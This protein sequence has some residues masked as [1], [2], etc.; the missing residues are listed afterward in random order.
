MSFI[1]EALRRS[2]SDRTG[3]PLS[4]PTVAATELLRAAENSTADAG[5]E[6]YEGSQLVLPRIETS[7]EAS[8]QTRAV[9]S[10]VPADS[11]LVLLSDQWGLAAEKF[12]LLGLRLRHSSQK[13]PLKKVLVTSTSVG[14][15]KSF[16]CANLAVTMS[17]KRDQR[18]LLLDGD[19]RRAVLNDR[20]GLG[21]LSGLSDCLKTGVPVSQGIYYVEDFG[22]W[23]L[24]A[25]NPSD[26]ALELMQSGNL[27]GILEELGKS[28]DWMII[29]SPPLTPL[30]DTALWSRLVDGTL[31]VTRQGTTEQRALQRGVEMLE[32]GNIFGVV[33]NGSSSAGNKNY[34]QY[35]GYWK[36]AT[37]KPRTVE[38][39]IS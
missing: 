27:S 21:Q 31:L 6:E 30:A 37:D 7:A 28:F 35:Y 9:R 39:P 14:E 16:V 36:P 25:G 8:V 22:F 33:L 26:N 5:A 24:P 34:Y 15:G 12:R 38:S 18:V 17:R 23:F 32:E 3:R 20:F 10:F 2:E 11:G 13:R 19:L 29:D 1:F 4:Q